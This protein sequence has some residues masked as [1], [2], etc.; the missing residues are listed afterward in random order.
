M[1]SQHFRS[2]SSAL[3]CPSL[4][5]T[6]FQAM[7]E[8]DKVLFSPSEHIVTPFTISRGMQVQPPAAALGGEGI[9]SYAGTPCCRTTAAAPSPATVIHLQLCATLPMQS[10]YHSA[11]PSAPVKAESAAEIRYPKC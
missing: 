3:L 7:S 6:R 1:Q 4:F 2:L 5:S 10:W 9:M 11:L 8:K